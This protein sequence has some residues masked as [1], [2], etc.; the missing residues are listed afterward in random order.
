MVQDFPGASVLMTAHLSL[1]PTH[2]LPWPDDARTGHSESWPSRWLK[3][4][5]P[6]TRL[7]SHQHGGCTARLNQCSILKLGEA[8]QGKNQPNDLFD[9]FPVS[10]GSVRRIRTAPVLK[11]A[12]R[13]MPA[14]HTSRQ[15]QRARGER[16][17][18]KNVIVE[19]GRALCT[20]TLRIGVI[21]ASLQDL[22]DTLTANAE[23][24]GYPLKSQTLLPQLGDGCVLLGIDLR[25]RVGMFEEESTPVVLAIGFLTRHRH[26]RKRSTSSLTGKCNPSAC[27]V[28]PF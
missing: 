19:P 24:V 2:N 21:A 10:D 8:G 22:M 20:A 13:E 3:F 27:P 25:V 11:F 4:S 14:S 23:T 7:C 12:T 18:R 28:R 26:V 16:R 1:S 5:A 6:L 9:E 15:L 17:T